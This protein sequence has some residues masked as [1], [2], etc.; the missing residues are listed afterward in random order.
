M[1]KTGKKELCE[2]SNHFYSI[3]KG[4]FRLVLLIS[5]SFSLWDIMTAWIETMDLGD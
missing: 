1:E 5:H 2:K 4:R 3:N